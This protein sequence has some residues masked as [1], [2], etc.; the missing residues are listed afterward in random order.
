MPQGLNRSVSSPSML[1]NRLAACL[2]CLAAADF[3]AAQVRPEP[4]TAPRSPAARAVAKK[5]GINTIDPET[6]RAIAMRLPA[7]K[8]P[9]I[10]GHLDDEVWELAQVAGAFIQREPKS[11]APASER[12]EFKILYD[13]RKIYFGIWCFDSDPKGIRASELKRDAMLMKGDHL[14]INIDTFHDHRNAFY[15]ATN[16]LGARKDS[17]STESGRTIN[18][19]WN[20]VWE[21]KT[22]R[23]EH[24]WYVEIAI[25]FSQLRFNSRLPETTWGLNLCRVIVRKNEDAYWAPFPRE[26]GTPGF[27]RLQYAGHLVGLNALQ[28]RRQLEFVP[29]VA[30]TIARDYDAGAS[31]NAAR[32]GFDVRLGLASN[33]TADLT[34]RTDFAQVEADEE[35]VNTS[36]FSLFFPEKRQFFTESA[37]IFDYGR[38][39][40]SGLTGPELAKTPG[41]LPI[42]YS[43]R[44]GL[45]DSGREV[46]L[47]GGARIAGRT[48]KYAIGVMNVE[49]DETT[50]HSGAND[51]IVPRANYTIIR[52]KRNI[53]SKSSIGGVFLSRQG[54]PG[55]GFNR[56]VGADLGL[57]FGSA[58]TITGMLARTFSPGTRGKDVA[59]VLDVAY[60][61]D[62]FNVGLTYVDIG[63]KFNAE[64]GFIPRT[65][66]RNPSLKGAWTPRPKW[67]GVRQVALGASAAYFGNHAGHVESRAG[68]VS[69]SIE[70]QDSAKFKMSVIH[71]DDVLPYAWAISPGRTVPVGGYDWN[72]FEVTYTTN[73]TRRV[74]G[75]ATVDLGG[76]YG[77]NKRTYQIN[78]SAVPFR[79]LLFET[80]YTRNDIELPGSPRYATTVLSSRVSY[81]FSPDLF[82]KSFVQYND[83][84]RS[85]S[86]N[87]LFW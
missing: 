46:R 71:N 56:A 57:A 68:D 62:V 58:T 6:L 25:P 80:F 61:T 5:P 44:I 51:L 15:F 16:P 22:S 75:S 24:G 4:T 81:S 35:V 43:R 26:L 55:A 37:G 60:R 19:D 29:F 14:K 73:Q 52:A 48:G 3:A 77:G 39:G 78:V 23:D 87:F 59:G 79:T 84:R 41:L 83:E 20:A 82:V 33:L 34:Y 18:Y 8:A 86:F 31:R 42:F 36:R 63:E 10:D 38:A 11:G 70:R 13:D 53:L 9:R 50:F 45:D 85:A 64:M 54:G 47:L 12:T 2:L 1:L 40:G 32:Y 65:D 27:S 76:Y 66:I 30:P 49:T 21:A 74:Y 17:N 69:F 7:G 67:R 72:T 28:S